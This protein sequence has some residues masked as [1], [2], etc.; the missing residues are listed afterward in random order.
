VVAVS[1]KNVLFVINHTEEQRSVSLPAGTTDLL[2]G[3]AA[4]SSVELGPYGVAVV[5]LD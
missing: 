1:L 5:R 4:G 2:T 3:G